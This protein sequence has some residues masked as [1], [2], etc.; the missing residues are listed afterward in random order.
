MA[1]YDERL[2]DEERFAQE[3]EI[4]AKIAEANEWERRLK[5]FISRIDK[6]KRKSVL[7]SRDRLIK[8]LRLLRPRLTEAEAAA[9]IDAAI[10]ID[11]ND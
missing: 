9:S 7:K 8:N 2:K 3:L 6:S 1:D 4:L 11:R 10:G 5:A